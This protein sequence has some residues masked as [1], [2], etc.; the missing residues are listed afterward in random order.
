MV[1]VVISTTVQRGSAKSTRRI[2]TELASKTSLQ[3]SMSRFS[4]TQNNHPVHYADSVAGCI[5]DVNSVLKKDESHSGI[6]H[7]QISSLLSWYHLH[8]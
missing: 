7:L 8:C 2:W 3:M 4:V 6:C 5:R 1:G